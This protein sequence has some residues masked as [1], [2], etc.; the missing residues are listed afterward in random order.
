[1]KYLVFILALLMAVPTVQA[2]C[3]GMGEFQETA[4]MSSDGGHDCC[5]ET[6][7]PEPSEEPACGDENHCSGCLISMSAVPASILIIQHEKPNALFFTVIPDTIPSYSLPPFR[8][9]IS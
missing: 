2:G 8:P 6:E 1:M 9:P 3:C 5:P 4:E 7:T